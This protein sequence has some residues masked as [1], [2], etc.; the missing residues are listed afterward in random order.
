M[1]LAHPHRCF[2]LRVKVA[3]ARVEL[4]RRM[5]A[6]HSECR[7]S[8]GSTTWLF[9]SK[10]CGRESNPQT[11]TFEIRRFAGLRTTAC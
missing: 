6:R 9:E 2:T 8:T 3:K 11:R 7:V 10:Y 1:S 5:W 4:A